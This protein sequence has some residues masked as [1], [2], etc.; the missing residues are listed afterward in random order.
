MFGTIFKKCF[1]VNVDSEID[2]SKIQPSFLI[3]NGW[4]QSFNLVNEVHSSL[5]ERLDKS[6]ALISNTKEISIWGEGNQTRSFTY[7]DDPIIGTVKLLESEFCDSLNIGSS[8][9]VTINQL[10]SMVE[11]IAGVKLKRKYELSATK[12]VRGR[13]SDNS[14]IRSELEWE[15]STSLQE[16]LEKTFAWVYSQRKLHF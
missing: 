6:D 16:G 7:I 15:P 1:V 11:A 2:H 14:L 10:V 13:N 12:G 8:E 3:L 9:M 4:F 5:V